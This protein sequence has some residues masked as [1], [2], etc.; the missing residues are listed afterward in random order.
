MEF[1]GK[2]AITQLII[3]YAEQEHITAEYVIG[4]IPNQEEPGQTEER[5]G[6]E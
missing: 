1:D 2:N 6:R 5:K 4:Q 3:L